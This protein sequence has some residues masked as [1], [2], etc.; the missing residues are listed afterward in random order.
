MNVEFS[1]VL[2]ILKYKNLLQVLTKFSGSDLV[3]PEHKKYFS[4][5]KEY[6]K[7]YSSVPL[8]KTMEEEFQISFEFPEQLEKEQ[9]Y[10]DKILDRN[11]KEKLITLLKDTGRKV[12]NDEGMKDILTFLTSNLRGLKTSGEEMLKNNIGRETL[13]RLE[14]YLEHKNGNIIWYK[15]YLNPDKDKK[16][17]IDT[18]LPLMGGRL[19]LVQAR[20]GVGKTF[21]ICK[22]AGKLAMNGVKVLF[23][24]KEMSGEEILERVDAFCCKIS[25]S[26]LTK[27]LLNQQEEEKYKN[28]L[29]G[30]EGKENLEVVF[31]PNCTQGTIKQLIEELQPNIVFIDYLQLIED[32]NKNKEKRHQF[33]KIIYDFKNFSQIY[34]I[35]IVVISA[36]NRDGA[37]TDSPDLSNISES[38]GVGFA[39]DA[40]ISLHQSEENSFADVMKFICNKNRHG[41]KFIQDLTWDISNSN[42]SEKE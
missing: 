35:P 13:K 37:K 15:W 32:E 2:S 10:I 12:V 16:S 31:P 9:Y 23:I 39:I 22:V 26:R 33:S 30:M 19:Y 14:R 25:Y 24:S 28:Y 17:K 42:I 29:M 4:F 21:L 7:K 3:I 20:P 1:L 40:L 27:G 18:E 34:K 5:L 38:D 36:T 6:Y 11:S 8:P 41:E